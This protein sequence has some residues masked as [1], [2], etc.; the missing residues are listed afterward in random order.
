MKCSEKYAMSRV[1]CSWRESLN[2]FLLQ[3]SRITLGRSGTSKKPEDMG[4]KPS[5][6]PS[7]V[8]SPGC[9]R[10]R[11]PSAFSSASTLPPT[12]D[13]SHVM[14]KPT[15]TSLNMASCRRRWYLWQSIVHVSFHVRSLVSLLAVQFNFP[16]KLLFEHCF[17][18]WQSW[19]T[20]DIEGV[21]P[22]TITVILH[23]KE[24]WILKMENGEMFY[25]YF[26]FIT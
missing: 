4:G 12:A 20:T 6:S 26:I 11:L 8:S 15:L 5:S 14:V 10:T 19:S 18:V 21:Y 3:P 7:A 9:V 17:L 1:S 16:R 22:S 23:L 2:D 13:D 24:L 25:I